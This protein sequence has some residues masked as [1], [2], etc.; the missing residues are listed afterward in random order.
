MAGLL[1]PPRKV[2]GAAGA[3]GRRLGAPA[4]DPERRERIARTAARSAAEQMDAQARRLL[5][6][7]ARPGVGSARERER[8]TQ[9]AA[10]RAQ[11]ARIQREQARAGAGGDR[12]REL[13]LAQRAQR[14]E[15]ELSGDG[16]RTPAD[17]WDSGV[18]GRGSGRDASRERELEHAKSFLDRQAALRA[19]A[20]GARPRRDYTALAGVIGREREEFERLAPGRQRLVRAEIDRELAL[21]NELPRVAGELARESRP[22]TVKRGDRQEA[23][24]AL[25]EALRRRMRDR[26][27]RLPGSQTTG[28]DAWSRRS[29]RDQRDSPVM[30]DAREVQRRRKRQLGRDQP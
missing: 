22:G 7:A 29:G 13:E 4:R 12:R 1:E 27:E 26:G 5:E 3:I 25:Q 16:Q 10:K 28:L 24:R 18:A 14:V 30:R 2:L 9:L 8:K 23:A 17:R 15:R 19:G 11:L 6:R 21:R 20:T